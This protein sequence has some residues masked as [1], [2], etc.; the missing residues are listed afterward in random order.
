M[1]QRCVQLFSKAV[2]AVLLRQ[3]GNPQYFLSHIAPSWPWNEAS[4]GHVKTHGIDPEVSTAIEATGQCF[5]NRRNPHRVFR[6]SQASLFHH[7]RRRCHRFRHRWLPTHTSMR[8]YRSKSPKKDVNAGV[9]GIVAKVCYHWLR[10]LAPTVRL[11]AGRHSSG[12]EGKI[13][14]FAS[15]RFIHEHRKRGHEGQTQNSGQS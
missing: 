7:Q 12:L 14:D 5:Q 2:T 6:P 3:T 11:H 8:R 4:H 1:K 15:Q 9:V 10:H 13:G